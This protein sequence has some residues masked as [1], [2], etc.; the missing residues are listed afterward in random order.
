V[1]VC[2][3]VCVWAGREEDSLREGEIVTE[4]HKDRGEGKRG[5]ENAGHEL[6]DDALRAGWQSRAVANPVDPVVLASAVQTSGLSAEAH[7]VAARRGLMSGPVSYPADSSRGFPA[8]SP[9]NSPPSLPLLRPPGSLSG[10]LPAIRHCLGRFVPSLERYAASG[11]PVD[12]HKALGDLMLAIT[13]ELA[14]G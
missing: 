3:C 8:T 11:Q 4:T 6:G 9:P 12:I 1:C 5:G 7:M 13:G 10:H 2:V 14:Y